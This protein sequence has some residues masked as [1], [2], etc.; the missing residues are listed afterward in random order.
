[1]LFSFFVERKKRREG[2]KRRGRSGIQEKKRREK[3]K[4]NP[5]FFSFLSVMSSLPWQ[6]NKHTNI[7]FFFTTELLSF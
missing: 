3:K 5:C 7:S 4:K 1:V 2:E 6:Q